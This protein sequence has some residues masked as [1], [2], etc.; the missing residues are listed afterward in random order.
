MAAFEL[1]HRY[2]IVMC[3]FSS[4]GYLQT[5]ARVTSALRCFHR[6]LADDGVIVVEPWF[7]PGVLRDGP[8][9][10]KRAEAGGVRVERASHTT[11]EGR[12]STLI[13]DYRV[14]DASGVRVAR[15]VHELGLFTQ[16]EM[17]ASFHEAGLAP[18]YDASGLTGR[19]LYVARIAP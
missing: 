19:G 18:T 11:V 2:D 6:H 3:L 13:F 5:L 12:L 16:A 7:A 15:E 14:E 1:G 9:S 10:T 17:I 4:I 8:G